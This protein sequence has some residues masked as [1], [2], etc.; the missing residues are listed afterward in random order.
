MNLKG[1]KSQL[2]RLRVQV[3]ERT[4][5]QAPLVVVCRPCGEDGEERSPGIYYHD[6]G[7]LECVVFDTEQR[8]DELVAR[9]CSHP[10]W[11][12][13]VVTCYPGR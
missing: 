4:L 8:R 6:T 11:N 5:A 2:A 9:V 3:A 1:M 10:M 12:P 7:R 13:L